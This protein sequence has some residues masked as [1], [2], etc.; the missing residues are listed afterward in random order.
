[1]APGYAQ[2]GLR[3]DSR[4]LR[5]DIP[6]EPHGRV[7]VRRMREVSKERD[8]VGLWVLV[9][10]R[11][12]VHRARGD[13]ESAANL[14]RYESRYFGIACRKDLHDVELAPYATVIGGPPVPIG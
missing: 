4:Q 1:M 10:S 14:W 9:R 11:G 2:A 6:G 12:Q 8:R 13:T 5:H 7:D 3:P